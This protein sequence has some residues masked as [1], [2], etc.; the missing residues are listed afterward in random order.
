MSHNSREVATTSQVKIRRARSGGRGGGEKRRKEPLP[1]SFFP[2]PA[3]FWHQVFCDLCTSITSTGSEAF[4][5]L[6]CLDAT[7]FV[8]LSVFTH[9]KTI[10]QKAGKN[11]CLRMGK[12]H[13]RL[14]YVAQKR[15]CFNSL[16]ILGDPGADSGKRAEKYMARRKVENGEKSPWGQCLTRPVP[17]G[18]RRSGFSEDAPYYLGA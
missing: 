2:S 8:L 17:N 3:P 5:L 11:H 4:S 10:C 7:R 9:I 14:T 16:L 1:S 18:R 15:L 13:F 6:I 12:V